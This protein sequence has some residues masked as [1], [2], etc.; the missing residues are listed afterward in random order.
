MKNKRKVIEKYL[1]QFEVVLDTSTVTT[2]YNGG[3]K[4]V[5]FIWIKSD[6]VYLARLENKTFTLK[7]F[8]KYVIR[9]NN[10]KAFW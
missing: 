10:L 2:Y 6:D 4:H 1:S 8:C 3:T 7:Q 9:L 5:N